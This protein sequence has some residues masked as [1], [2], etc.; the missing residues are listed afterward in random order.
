MSD[1]QEDQQ[2]HQDQEGQAAQQDVQDPTAGVEETPDRALDQR[3]AQ[4][5]ASAAAAAADA[6]NRETREMVTQLNSSFNDLLELVC[7]RLDAFAEASATSATEDG[8]ETADT[9]AEETPTPTTTQGDPGG[10]EDKDAKTPAAKNT[11]EP[12]DKSEPGAEDAE[13]DETTATD[14]KDQDEEA[15]TEDETQTQAAAAGDSGAPPGDEKDSAP[16]PA[17][18]EPSP[19]AAA[20]H[21]D[22]AAERPPASKREKQILRQLR[23]IEERLS[24]KPH[25]T[26]TQR[27]IIDA[28]SAIR[29]AQEAQNQAISAT[30]AL[31]P[32]SPS[33]DPDM[34]PAE[35]ALQMVM[36]RLDDI[37]RIIRP[38]P[39][40]A[41]ETLPHPSE[42]T[43]DP[44]ALPP[45]APAI[46]AD[47]VRA[48]TTELL[49]V[50]ADPRRG[51]ARFA[52]TAIIIVFLTAAA[53]G[54][55]AQQQFTLIALPDDTNGW[56][57]RVWELSGEEIARCIAASTAL[58][59]TCAVTA[60]EGGGASATSP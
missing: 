28:L 10:E 21:P 26:P 51:F 58:G 57:D 7:E 6:M 5:Q 15:A 45:P 4:S 54:S 32:S 2:A 25:T 8:K 41:P 9:T 35:Q 19:P 31:M 36:S 59:G 27:E 23:K 1:G 16:A 60:E 46:D 33:A 37:V 12:E 24:R 53:L 22:I 56:K 18:T 49:A 40:E 39:E 48:A 50:A 47:E 55:I 38:V 42:P 43:P 14:P 34:A 17:S 44:P 52:W 3:R 20:G 29:S 11:G 13:E 30:A